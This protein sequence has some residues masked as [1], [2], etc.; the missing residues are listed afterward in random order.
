MGA[1]LPDLDTE[2]ELLPRLVA[3]LNLVMAMGWTKASGLAQRV[4]NLIVRELLL[5]VDARERAH[6]HEE[7]PQTIAW[8]EARA[9]LPAD[10]YGPMDRLW[11]AS[12]YT[13]DPKITVAGSP[14]SA[15]GGISARPLR[16]IEEFHALVGPSGLNLLLSKHTKWCAAAWS[17]WIGA[18]F[19]PMLGIV[20][21]SADKACGPRPSCPNSRHSGSLSPT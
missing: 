1:I 4:G 14:P 10:E 11:D 13:D 19:C 20:W 8:L 16:V 6:R 18:N 12:I 2:G 17:L 21:V 15:V 3:V 7:A 9:S 5:R